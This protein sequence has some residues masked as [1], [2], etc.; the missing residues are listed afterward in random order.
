MGKYI[1]V[2]KH[3]IKPRSKP[4]LVINPRGKYSECGLR[5]VLRG[6]NNKE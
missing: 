2:L 5:S 3:K 6:F 1:K 4:L